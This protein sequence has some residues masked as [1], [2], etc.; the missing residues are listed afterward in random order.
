MMEREHV[1]SNLS[2]PKILME[3][4]AL[5][6]N[7]QLLLESSYMS[8]LLLKRCWQSRLTKVTKSK[9]ICIYTHTKPNHPSKQK[10]HPTG[11][12]YFQERW[13]RYTF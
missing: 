3:V 10:T 1:L 12:Y 5:D 2:F 9:N 13:L 6:N 7:G 11:S 8:L 4:L